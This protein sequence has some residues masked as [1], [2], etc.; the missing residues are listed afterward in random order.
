MK[1]K[2]TLSVNVLNDLLTLDIEIGKLFWKPRNPKQF[3]KSSKTAE[4]QCN[5][6]NAKHAGKEA[7]TAEMTGYKYGRINKVN[8]LAHRII[9]KMLYGYDPIEIDHKDGDRTNNRPSNLREVTTQQ[10]GTNKSMLS[11]NTSGVT[12]VW[13]DTSRNR[14]TA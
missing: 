5:A 9:F 4:H 10:N 13:F 6:W 11:N 12:G 14:W 1:I 7:F 3:K 8:F 2:E